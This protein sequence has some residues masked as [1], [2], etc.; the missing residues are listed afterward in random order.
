[1]LS[2]IIP[3]Y[4]QLIYTRNCLNYLSLLNQN[5]IEVLLINNNSNDGT[6][7]F[8]DNYKEI[9]NFKV[10]Y[11]NKNTGF[12]YACNQGFKESSGN[13]ILF[14]N[15]DIK[16]NDRNIKWNEIIEQEIENNPN[17]LVGPT[18]G[19]IKKDYSYG[20]ETNDENTEINYMSGWCLASKKNILEKLI[21]GSNQGPF[22]AEIYFCYFEDTHMSFLATKLGINFKIID[23][24][25]VHLGK[26]TSATINTGKLYLESKEKFI[27]IWK[28]D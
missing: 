21:E 7:E 12:G 17:C 9:K 26:K 23:L 10:I 13:N 14:L 28:K 15:N 4:N 25:L 2:I 22:N 6:K 11:N 16:L 5:N 27:K 19:F 18:G 3:V 24:P 20:Y 1:M 8:L